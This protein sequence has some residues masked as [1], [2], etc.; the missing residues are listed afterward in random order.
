MTDW[1]WVVA[2]AEIVMMALRKSPAEVWVEVDWFGARK[3]IR[4]GT[5]FCCW[6]H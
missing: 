2:F 3:D 6:S 5:R 4:C 1:S